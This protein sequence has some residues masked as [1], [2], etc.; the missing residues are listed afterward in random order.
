MI[1]QA[2]HGRAYGLD[3]LVITDHGSN[4]HAKIGVEKVNPDIRATRA[5]L[6]D[7]LTFQGLE[8]NIPGAEHATVF[9]H[10]GKNEVAVLK[11]FELTYDGSQL[12]ATNTEAQNE[13]TAIAGIKFLAEQVRQRKVDGAL[14]LANHPAR[15]GIDSPHEIRNWRDAAPEVAI[16]FEGAPGH[17]AAGIPAPNGRG[18]ARGFYDNSPSAASF[19]GY[20]LESYRTWGGFDWMTATVGGLWDSLLA[21]GKAWWITVNSDSHVNY[22]DQSGRGPGSDFEANGKYNDPVYTGTVN[23]SAGDFWPGFYGRTNVGA[24]AFSYKAVMDGLRAGRVWVD[25]GRLI[26]S[27]DTRVRVAGDRRGSSG[28]PLGGVLHVKRGTATELTIDIDL[29]DV[30]NWRQFIP[31]LKRVDVI[32]GS[33]TGPVADKDSFKAPDTKVVKSFEV[34][35]T[36]GS[37]SFTYSLGRLDKPFYLRLRGTDGNRTQPGLMGA[38]VDPYGPQ[39]D[40]IGSADPWADL[41]FYTNPIWVLPR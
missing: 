9:V 23:T 4:A 21:E 27:L 28:T 6:R 3:W 33:V 20:P 31:V 2:Q 34:D 22:L 40:V 18:G 26:K 37:V 25:H 30:P 29:Q 8:W 1:D 24:S 16:G 36:R 10:P 41:W 35:P 7:L 19:A 11:Q 32:V 38:A 17:Q 14:F 12:P 39:L 15:R 5:E 13:A